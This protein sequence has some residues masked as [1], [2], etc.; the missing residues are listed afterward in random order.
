MRI[1]ICFTLTYFKVKDWRQHLTL[2]QKVSISFQMQELVLLLHE[3][4]TSPLPYDEDGS[5]KV[6]VLR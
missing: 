1:I 2:T 3:D 4:P 5:V 6:E